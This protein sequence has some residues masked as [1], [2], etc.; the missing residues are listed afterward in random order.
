MSRIWIFKLYRCTILE[1]NDAATF[2]KKVFVKCTDYR[3]K[4]NTGIALFRKKKIRND[5]GDFVVECTMRNKQTPLSVIYES[6]KIV[7]GVSLC[8]QGL[9]QTPMYPETLKLDFVM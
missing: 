9:Q 2:N 7:I 3:R 4:K 8:M 6:E 1:K 5:L